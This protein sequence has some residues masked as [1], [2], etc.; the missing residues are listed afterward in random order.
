MKSKQVISSFFHISVAVW[1]ALFVACS[2]D[3]PVVN[4]INKP[5]FPPPPITGDNATVTEAKL[6]IDQPDFTGQC[7]HSFQLTGTI[8]T[9]SPGIVKYQFRDDDAMWTLV[10]NLEFK[11]AGTQMITATTYPFQTSTKY[12]FGLELIAPK[13]QIDWKEVTINCQ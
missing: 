3:N 5:I 13:F 1:L 12:F 4:N 10:G 11:S 2:G 8:T 6:S 7:P 9:S